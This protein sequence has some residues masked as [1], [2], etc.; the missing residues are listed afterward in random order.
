MR[1]NSE[2]RFGPVRLAPGYTAMNAGT[3]LLSACITI[4][5]FAFIV[6]IQPYL[7]NANL[8]VPA[9]E[10]GRLVGSLGFWGEFVSLALVAPI[11]ALADKIG[12]RPVYAAGFLWLAAAFFVYPM[13]RTVPQL[14]AC[15][16][17]FA[18]GTAAVGCMLA[19]ILADTPRD[20]SRGLLAGLTGICQGLGAALAVL[21]L[22]GVPKRMVAAGMDPTSAGRVTLGIAA[23][24]C[25]VTAV[26]CLLGLRKG[27]PSRTAARAPLAVVMRDGFEAARRNPRIWFAYMLQFV[28]FGDRIVFGTYFSLRLQQEAI[29]HGISVTDAV[30]AARRPFVI[31]SAASLVFA[32][33]FGYLLDKLDRLTVSIIAMAIAGVGYLVASLVGDPHSPSIVPIALMLGLGQIASIISSQTLLGQEA[34]VERRGAVFGMAGICGSLAVLFTQ[35]VGGRLYDTVSRGAPFVLLGGIA[36]IV[37]CFGLWLK[38]SQRSG[39]VQQQ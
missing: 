8:N 18:V 30:T 35:G 9:G 12:R 19:T 21:V 5:M 17:F 22:G 3:Y 32:A 39:F 20:E 33:V 36:L 15:A 1:S 16:F 26:I 23:A 38:F 27:T 10:Q 13:A 34:P 4:G 31:A 7:I 37:M 14:Y 6:F 25:F 29:A 11:G 24:L 28:S 2:N